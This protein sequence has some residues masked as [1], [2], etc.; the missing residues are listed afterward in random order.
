MA[1]KLKRELILN[2]S[3]DIKGYLDDKFCID[4]D[5]LDIAELIN[6][7]LGFVFNVVEGCEDEWEDDSDRLW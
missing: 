2:A 1:N 7:N 6:L 3:E 4:V 5:E